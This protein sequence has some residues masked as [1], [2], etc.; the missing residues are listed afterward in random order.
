MGVTGDFQEKT[1]TKMSNDKKG[2]SCLGY[3]GASQNGGT[4]QQLVVLL[5]MTI[6]GCFGGTTI[7]G[8][9]QKGNEILHS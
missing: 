9:T 8:N 1:S 3:M 5:K 4:Q 6:L 2:P 7:L